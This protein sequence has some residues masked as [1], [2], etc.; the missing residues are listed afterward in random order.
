MLKTFCNRCKTEMTHSLNT[1]FVQA[2]PGTEKVAVLPTYD[3]CENC[4]IKARAFMDGAE[5]VVQG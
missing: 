1:L 4:S 3:L 2:K 5:L